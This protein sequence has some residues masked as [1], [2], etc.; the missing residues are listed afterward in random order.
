VYFWYN[1]HTLKPYPSR[2]EAL[3]DLDNSQ[4]YFFDKEFR[5]VD[6]SVEPT[7]SLTELYKERALNLR[8][9]YEYLILAYSGG[10]DSTNVLETFYYNNIHLDEILIVGAL[11]QDSFPGSDENHNGELYKNCFPTLKKLHMPN[12]KITIGNYTEYFDKPETFR[13]IKNYQTDWLYHLNGAYNSAHT[14]YWDDLKRIIGQHNDKKTAILFGSAK[15]TIRRDLPDDPDKYYFRF[16]DSDFMGFANS[17]KRPN[18]DNYE[19]VFFYT[20]I[21]STKL[22]RK[23]LHVLKNCYQLTND[24]TEWLT[25]HRVHKLIYNLKNPLVFMSPKATNSA[26]GHRDF[27]LR[28]AKTSRMLDIHRESTRKYFGDN[29]P[30]KMQ[31]IFARKYYI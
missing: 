29:I 18:G 10:H 13:L 20:D 19:R 21:E 5:T 31:N 12:T 22:M 16:V 1:K 14:V 4:F 25:I 8:E 30:T 26:L 9:K 28:R 17:I 15:T 7:E 2:R 3:I 23:Q 27:Y 6:W 11:S 24:K